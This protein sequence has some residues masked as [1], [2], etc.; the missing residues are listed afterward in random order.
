MKVEDSSGLV[1]AVQVGSGGCFLDFQHLSTEHWL[2]FRADLSVVGL[3]TFW[4]CLVTDQIANFKWSQTGFLNLMVSSLKQPLQSLDLS[5]NVTLTFGRPQRNWGSSYTSA[6]DWTMEEGT[7]LPG[8]ISLIGPV[9][10]KLWIYLALDR[11]FSCLRGFLDK[12]CCCVV[13]PTSAATVGQHT[14]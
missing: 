7:T 4:S 5:P 12:L 14:R 8:L 3:T 10:M 2:K 13:G 11:R 1:S 9:K 6:K